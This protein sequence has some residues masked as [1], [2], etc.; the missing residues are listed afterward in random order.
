MTTKKILLSGLVGG[1]V[2]FIL[3][4]LA[5]GVLLNNFF[6][7]NLGSATGVMRGEDEMMWGPMI[8][9]HLALGM[10]FAI[11]YGRWASISTFTT[12]AKAG[13]VLGGLMALSYDMIGLGTTHVMN[14]TGAI[15]DV[16]VTVIVSSLIGGTVAWFLG[17]DAAK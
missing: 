15:S 10:L 6:Q 11:I 14:L 1:V 12:G 17:R 3:G 2:A 8:I 7:A 9:G 4:F 5:W 16:V 13:A